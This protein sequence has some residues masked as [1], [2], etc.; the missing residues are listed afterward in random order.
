MVRLRS[1]VGSCDAIPEA[2]AGVSARFGICVPRA[3]EQAGAKRGTLRRDFS[4]RKE[5]MADLLARSAPGLKAQAPQRRDDA[6]SLQ[7]RAMAR[8]G[9]RGGD[10][11][12]RRPAGLRS[13]APGV[14]GRQ[15][16][17]VLRKPPA[18]SCC[19]VLQPSGGLLVAG[20]VAAG[21]RGAAKDGR[22]ALARRAFCLLGG[23][24]TGGM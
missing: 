18:R 7:L 20:M 14:A 3:P 10:F 21:L 12:S 23:G 24:I 16:P 2:A 11:A 6:L 17:E 19:P 5:R 8:R 22:R 13:S 1:A 15:S 4:D 9:G